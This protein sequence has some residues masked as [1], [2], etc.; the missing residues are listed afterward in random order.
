MKLS[1]RILLLVISFT[2]SSSLVVGGLA[3]WE[4]QKSGDS[5]QRHLETLGQKA[6]QRV[7]EDGKLQN[8]IF[9]AELVKSK[10]E[11]LKSQV[12]VTISLL[13]K[14]YRDAKDPVKMR[15]VYETP[16]KNAVETAF[17]ILQ[18]VNGEKGLDEEQKK[19]KA[20]YLIKHL[21][22]GPEN[23]DYFWINTLG[24]RMVMHPY[25][26]DLESKDLSGM[27]DSKGKNIFLEFIKACRKSG[28][29]FVDYYWPKYGA[30]EPQPKLSFVKLFKPWEWV[31]G[32]GVYM[33]VAETKLKKDYLDIVRELRYGPQGKDYF[34]INDMDN[35]ML[36][37]PGNPALE[38]TDLADLKDSNGKR[39]FT[40][41]VRVCKEKGSGFVEYYWPK[42]GS[43]KPQPKLS[44]VELFKP[45]GWV[46]GTGIY[47][48][49]IDKA[50]AERE[51][52]TLEQVKKAS[53]ET[54]QGVAQ[55]KAQE[56]KEILRTLYLLVIITLIVIVAAIAISLFFVR[57]GITLPIQSMMDR[58][59]SGSQQVSEASSQV[60]RSS[61]TLA[62]NSSTQAASLEETSAS[63][64]EIASM[65]PAKR[66]QREP[67][68]RTHERSGAGGEAGHPRH[69]GIEVGHGK[70][71]RHQQRNFQ[72]H[73]DHR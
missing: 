21:R 24:A 1:T 57:R 72:D 67:G 9:R 62:G 14:A 50:M 39:F 49:D 55:I 58:L 56:E 48:D 53:A 66:R 47:I 71:N 27:K 18:A 29:G 32:T 34:W 23:K 10:K 25:K 45:W 17:S 19:A 63:M 37:H 69:A 38:G 6:I 52:Q 3:I 26:P 33:E 40:E 20:A 54:A 2:L 68:R 12:Q 43:D 22:Y 13:K 28:Q 70:H 46:I 30:D 44:Y 42:M 15:S 35:R 16:L 65:T 36:M 60:S 7:K 73:Q 11:Y 64:E 5:S 31:I 51:A 8:K 59:Y 61:E 4:L 41:M